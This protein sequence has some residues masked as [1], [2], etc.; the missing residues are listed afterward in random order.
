MGAGEKIETRSNRQVWFSRPESF[1]NNKHTRDVGMSKRVL[2]MAT[3]SGSTISDPATNFSVFAVDDEIL[4]WG[5][6]LNNGTRAILSVGSS[7]ITVDWPV[8][9][10][11][12]I[13]VEIRT[14]SRAFFSRLGKLV[15]AIGGKADMTQTG[16]HFRV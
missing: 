16:R 8:Q 6:A 11:G 14:T 4:I 12:P 2:P 15:S 13:A 3:F 1:P 7:F 10:E 9:T 5:S